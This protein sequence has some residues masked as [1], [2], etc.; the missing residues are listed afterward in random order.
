MGTD[1]VCGDV[2]MAGTRMHCGDGD[3]NRVATWMLCG[4]GRSLS[5]H[6][7]GRH[8]DALR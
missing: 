5:G 6:Y 3:V 4:N 8:M 2:V 7:H 1:G